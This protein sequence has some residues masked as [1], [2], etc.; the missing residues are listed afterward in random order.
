M[1]CQ[2]C[3]K[4]ILDN[5]KFCSFCGV[6]VNGSNTNEKPPFVEKSVVNQRKLEQDTRKGTLVYL[7]DI[8]SMEFSVNKLEHALEN[9]QPLITIHDNWF[10]CKCFTFNRRINGIPNNPFFL[11]KWGIYLSYSY[12]LNKYYYSFDEGI[13]PCFT[14]IQKNTVEYQF[15]NPCKFELTQKERDM[16]CTPPVLEKRLFSS[17][18][19]IV[20]RDST[21]WSDDAIVTCNGDQIEVFSQI[22]PIIEQFEDLVREREDAYQKQLPEL[23]REIEEIEKELSD[24]KRILANLYEMNLIPSKYRNIGCAYFIH[25]FFSTSRVPL[26]NVFLHLDL[27]KIQSELDTVINNQRDSV[28]QEAIIISQ[29]EEIISQNQKVFNEL[30]DMNTTLDNIRESDIETSKWAR[31]AALSADTCAWISLANYI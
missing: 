10:L 6:R 23:K 11:P 4:Q 2:Q 22:K 16:L 19:A 5:S 15:D 25:D 27:D 21:F 9:K 29:N 7:H 1:Y 17:Y 3:G 31:I 14:D 24:A 20:N 28:L 18:Y 8:L 30:S 26:N 13:T 12:K